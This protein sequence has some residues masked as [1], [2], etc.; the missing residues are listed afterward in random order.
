MFFWKDGGFCGTLDG[1]GNKSGVG[2]T[3]VVKQREGSSMRVL[4]VGHNGGIDSDNEFLLRVKCFELINDETHQWGVKFGT[5]GIDAHYRADEFR[6]WST[7]M[8]LKMSKR[9][10][11][12]SVG[13]CDAN[14]SNT[15]QNA[16]FKWAIDNFRTF[17]W[18]V[19][20]LRLASNAG[21]SYGSG[22]VY[23]IKTAVQFTTRRRSR[24]SREN[25]PRYPSRVTNPTAFHEWRQVQ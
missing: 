13:S 18:K 12:L 10:V 1:G 17:W 16:H 25:V 9:F 22:K 7:L 14:E 20:A 23:A 19:C 3:A 15:C 11:F 5:L 8:T 21:K 4:W 24:S 2:R 6:W